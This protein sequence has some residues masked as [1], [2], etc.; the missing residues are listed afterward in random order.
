[1]EQGDRLQVPQNYPSHPA[2]QWHL[3]RLAFWASIAAVS[4]LFVSPA[5]VRAQSPSATDVLQR[6]AA[7]Y[8]NLK[9]YQAR[10]SLQSV[11]GGRVA[12]RDFLETGSGAAFRA[13][14]QDPKARIRVSDG[15]TEWAFDR[16]L[17]QF[18]KSAPQDSDALVRSLSFIDQNVRQATLDDPESY[19]AGS[20]AKKAFIIE[21]TRTLWPFDASPNAQ[22]VIYTIDASSYEVYKSITYTPDSTEIAYYSLTQKDQA[23]PPSEFAFSAPQGA[24]QVDRLAAEAW[25]YKPIV[26]MQAPD[27][28]LKDPTGQR[29]IRLSN[30]RG[31]VV[32]IAFVGSWCAACSA[33]LPYVQQVYSANVEIDLEAFALDVGDDPKVAS[34]Y[35]A[36]SVLSFPMLVGAEPDVTKNY[37]VDDFPTTYVIGRDGKIAFKATGTEN[38]GGFLAA[39]K[40]AVARK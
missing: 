6:A 30:Y 38:P 34:D 10:V 37:F 9:S 18:A 8:R 23:V 1:V 31:K 3:N 26:G 27:F 36:N 24:T 35:D 28:A 11:S 21:V 40:A 7:T 22:S 19:G 2:G 25:A 12:E 15:T 29:T 5:A 16:A 20:A 17:N 33:Q 14:E 4:A 39:V 13:E 32:A